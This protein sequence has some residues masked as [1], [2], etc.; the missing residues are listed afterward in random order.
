MGWLLVAAI[1]GSMVVAANL[2]I[3]FGIVYPLFW[4]QYNA[5]GVH[6]FFTKVIDS[7]WVTLLELAWLF[8]ALL[9]LLGLGT[10]RLMAGNPVCPLV[11]WPLTWWG[12][13][14]GV[15]GVPATWP[16]WHLCVLW[17]H[18]DLTILV[19]VLAWNVFW[20]G[21]VR[22]EDAIRPALPPPDATPQAA[23]IFTARHPAMPTLISLA[24]Y[25][26]RRQRAS[27]AERKGEQQP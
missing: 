14:P 5:P 12:E 23:A 10:P 24:T 21:V 16:L 25:R 18:Y 19:F 9:V 2:A 3:M 8:P 15:P 4:D 27:E 1:G 11:S 22:I 13:H 17:F 26:A 20:Y 7:R 6:G